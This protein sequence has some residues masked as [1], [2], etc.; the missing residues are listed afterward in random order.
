MKLNS[1]KAFP[2]RTALAFWM[3]T[4]S[5]ACVHAQSM[6]DFVNANPNK[7]SF[8][9]IINDSI[10][11]GRNQYRMM[12]AASLSKTII[13][14][15]F[16]YQ[17]ASGDQSEEAM[18]SMSDIDY[19]AIGDSNYKNWK[20]QIKQDQLVKNDQIALKYVVQGMIRYSA[21]ACADY[22]INRLGL[23]NINNRIRLLN[24]THE[25]IFPF[26]ASLLHAFN[27][28]DMD[29]SAFIAD[30]KKWNKEEYLDQVVLLHDRIM[31]DPKFWKE[32]KKR[33][34]KSR[35]SDTDYDSIWTNSF[36]QSTAYAYARL[37]ADI[38]KRKL[39]P[40]FTTLVQMIF[41][42]WTFSDNPQLIDSFDRVAYKG[43]NSNSLIN[44]WLYLADQEGNTM[45][46]VGLFNHLTKN[47]YAIVEQNISNFGFA[48]LT[49]PAM[50]A[51]FISSPF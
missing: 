19:L 12:P 38:N 34:K 41:E 2:L 21:N 43:A 1:P 22:L 5:S 31:T 50:R 17:V 42:K 25:P 26:T 13:A 24:L 14:L 30:A 45:Q 29:K 39:A 48:L 32:T 49:D 40:E 15:E 35:Y 11:F 16:I 6:E 27:Y 3:L 4:L 46:F 10:E 51:K 9:V 44:I 47:E 7:V 23:E 28:C 20:K 36:S 33:I 37:I 8:C 18:V